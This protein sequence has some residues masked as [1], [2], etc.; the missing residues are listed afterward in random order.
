MERVCRVAEQ[1]DAVADPSIDLDEAGSEIADLRPRL[2]RPER[3]IQLRGRFGH[4]A[5]E[6]FDSLPSQI[7]KPTFSDA[8]EEVGRIWTGGHYSKHFSGRLILSRTVTQFLY[9][10]NHTDKERI[11]ILRHLRDRS[12]QGAD[13]GLW[14]VSSNHDPRVNICLLPVDID[15]HP[16]GHSVLP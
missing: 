6:L 3:I 14:S 15:P 2:D 4:L 7:I 8:V 12:Y 5:S 13:S 11:R 1:R 16:L 9:R 10:S